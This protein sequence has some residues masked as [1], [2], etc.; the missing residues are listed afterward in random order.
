MQDFHLSDKAAV[1]AALRADRFLI[2]KHSHRCSVSH[3]AFAE[4]TAFAA[5]HSG[6]AH[7]WVDVVRQRELS[8]R[9]EQMTGVA[10]GSPQAIWIVAGRAGWHASH[11]DITRQALAGSVQLGTG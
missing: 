9:I 2:F 6:V 11:F 1:D 3:R 8:N 7:G 10:H 4:Y 5:A